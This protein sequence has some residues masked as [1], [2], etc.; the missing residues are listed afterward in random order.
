MQTMKNPQHW[1]AQHLSREINFDG[2]TVINNEKI[3]AG[4]NEYFSTIGSKLSEGIKDGDIDPLS[5]MTVTHDDIFNF[6][7]ITIDEVIDALNLIQSK[8]S[9]GLDGISARLLKDGTHNIAG[10][11]VDIFNLSLRTAIFPDD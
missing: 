10:P 6:N 5:F 1:S 7:F 3:A 4:F 9:S 2:E 8:K 11:L